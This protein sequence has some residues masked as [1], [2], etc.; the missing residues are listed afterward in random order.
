MNSQ[1]HHD[2][3][4]GA[5]VDYH[6]WSTGVPS[7]QR[8]MPQ[9]NRLPDRTAIWEPLPQSWFDDYQISGNNI[10]TSMQSQDNWHFNDMGQ[11]VFTF[12]ARNAGGNLVIGLTGWNHSDLNGYYIV[13]DDDNHESYVLKV[14][15]LGNDGLSRTRV[16]GPDVRRARSY[17]RVSV[18]G[19]YADPNFRLNFDSPQRFWVMYQRGTIVVGEG[20]VPGQGRV[21]LYMPP[22]PQATSEQEGQRRTL[23]SDLYHY[24]FARHGSRWKTPINIRNTQSYRYRPSPNVP[25]GSSGGG[26]TP[27]FPLPSNP[28]GNPN[29]NARPAP[30]LEGVLYRP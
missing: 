23:G 12:E 24:G 30:M 3:S 6:F 9:A 11:G 27:L 14:K 13:L 7:S 2:S 26:M 29:A 5:S 28:A 16:D 8:L 18:P 20:A 1:S 10:Q 15:T 4:G 22:E 17:D 25:R 21:I 19:F